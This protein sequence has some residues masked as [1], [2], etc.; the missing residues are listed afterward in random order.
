[1]IYLAGTTALEPADLRWHL[2]ALAEPKRA[3]D[4][5]N[6]FILIDLRSSRLNSAPEYRADLSDLMPMGASYVWMP[7]AGDNANAHHYTN[8]GSIDVAKTLESTA[9]A[10]MVTRLADLVGNDNTSIV[11]L[12]DCVDHT[13]CVR[14]ALYARGVLEA[15][16][17]ETNIAT[18]EPQR[19]VGPAP[20]RAALSTALLPR[21][22]ESQRKTHLNATAQHRPNPNPV[23]SDEEERAVLPLLDPTKPVITP[24][25]DAPLRELHPTAS[26]PI[27]LRFYETQYRV[28][29]YLA[30]ADALAVRNGDTTG[31][32]RIFGQASIQSAH[33]M[34]RNM[35]NQAAYP[36]ALEDAVRLYCQAEPRIVNAL[37]ASLPYSPEIV[38]SGMT[39]QDARLLSLALRTLAREAAETGT[40]APPSNAATV[41]NPLAAIKIIPAQTH[42]RP[43]IPPR[44]VSA[45]RPAYY[46]Y[47]REAEHYLLDIITKSDQLPTLEDL[48]RDS[49]RPLIIAGV[50]TREVKADLIA[51]LELIAKTVMEQGAL[52]RS[53]FAAGTDTLYTDAAMQIANRSEHFENVGV[54]FQLEGFTP[55]NLGD[56]EVPDTIVATPFL[57]E[58]R[59]A[60][61]TEG[62]RIH[63]KINRHSKQ[64]EKVAKA[65]QE[66]TQQGELSE[67]TARD[68]YVP[69]LFGRNVSI[70]RGDDLATPV[71]VVFATRN[72]DPA[73]GEPRSPG[74]THTIS[75]AQEIR[76][77]VIDINTREQAEEVL[78]ALHVRR[79][80]LTP[81]TNLRANLQMLVRE[82]ERPALI[83]RQG[84]YAYVEDQKH[85]FATS[86]AFP[87]IELDSGLSLTATDV[88]IQELSV[89]PDHSVTIALS[90]AHI[91]H[92]IE[93][94]STSL[95][96]PLDI[97]PPTPVTLSLDHTHLTSDVS[98]LRIT[99]ADTV[100]LRSTQE[101]LLIEFDP[102][103]RD[104]IQ[105][106]T[107]DVPASTTIRILSSPTLF[108][109]HNLQ[110]TLT[111][112][113][114]ATEGQEHAIAQDVATR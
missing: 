2:R 72:I 43:R 33:I 103:T 68:L 6:A 57:P 93:S 49:S 14:G 85:I 71:D 25:P 64:S 81:K 50:G 27:T 3:Q 41:H 66:F 21:V 63:S 12:C 16:V 65:L 10:R 89:S 17:N 20:T 40:V 52:V 19:V 90:G 4:G 38:Q 99:R 96:L 105:N 100:T 30:L 77:P 60:E 26:H 70:V 35:R 114:Q 31:M 36:K 58:E 95:G 62:A 34:G 15:G 76:I 28:P 47:E 86:A 97:A 74:T 53:G 9:A 45:E 22:P 54:G 101:D 106:L 37:A 48:P 8:E 55:R 83:G 84:S 46:F 11:L 112:G 98:H 51:P 107:L 44:P 42:Q 111:L 108:S 24:Y 88:Y 39:P 5:P 18:L 109:E 73:T 92:L 78:S 75:L 102:V 113:R 79:P 32:H 1:M 23:R 82:E 61:L 80:Y 59:W 67:K 104:D 13:Q 56:I 29:G 87:P 69:A 94:P 110:A 7:N 91:D